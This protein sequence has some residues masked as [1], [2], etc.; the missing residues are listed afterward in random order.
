MKWQIIDTGIAQAK[1]NMACD[2]HLLDTL[3]PRGEPILHFYDWQGDSATYGYFINPTDFFDMDAVDHYQLQLARRPTGGG[4]VF[5]IAD[6]A[7]S[8]L[9]PAA[10]DAFSLNILDNYAFVNNVVIDTV[11]QVCSITDDAVLLEQEPVPYDRQCRHF[12]MAKPT[13]Y[14]V[15]INDKKIGGAAQRRTKQGFLHQG[16]ISIAAL[17]KKYLGDILLPGSRVLEAMEEN[18]FVILEEGWSKDELVAMRGE[19]R[20]SLQEMFLGL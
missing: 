6:F 15:I 2:K 5:H 3:D 19:L 10:H 13:K 7:F 12:C 18:S 8:A 20:A 16:T 4:I 11:K 1:D 14:D 9:V 17:S